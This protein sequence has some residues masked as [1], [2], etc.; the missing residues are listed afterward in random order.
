MTT[1]S[2]NKVS[3]SLAVVMTP[4][5]G[6][7]IADVLLYDAWAGRTTLDFVTS[8][9]YAWLE[10][11]DVITLTRNGRSYTVRLVSEDIAGGL[12]RRTAVM[13]DA[14][15]YTQT[16][17]AADSVAVDESVD[18]V[19]PTN[20]ELLDIPL[21]RSQDDGIGFYAAAAGFGTSTSWPGAQLFKSSDGGT[22]WVESGAA[23]TALGNFSQNI[24]DEHGSVTVTL[25]SG[26]LSSDTEANVLNGAN[27][28]VLGD[29]LI[30]F[31][32]ATLIS[33]DTYTLTGLLRGR[34]GTEWVRSTHAIGD[35]FIL[36]ETD[37]IYLL[38]SDTSEVDLERTY[39]AVTFDG[40]LD[41][42]DSESFTNTAVSLV[43]YAPIH[44]GGGRNA[45]LDIT[46]NWIRRTRI[47]GGWNSYADVPL[48][49]DSEA[50]EV[51]IYTAS[52]YATVVRTIS[53]AR[54]PR[55]ISSSIKSRPRSAAAMKPEESS[56]CPAQPPCSTPSAAVRRRKKSPRT[57]CSMPP[58]RP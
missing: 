10:P 29:E 56:K 21:L 37:T 13:E 48:G 4:A 3:Q 51:E 24:F 45:A 46:L 25:D 38:P 17:T 12:H 54:K 15:V 39:R 32:T 41:D 18:V 40:Y 49:E 42:T 44:L 52:D 14:S 9:K 28:A 7:E 58:A 43:P 11:T 19:T 31:R 30:Q 1:D 35:R 22:T 5:K 36:L 33:A 2:M 23:T 53:A 27:S 34:L 8:W 6:K 50:Y 55:S 57:P 20:L 26:D 16:A 47:N